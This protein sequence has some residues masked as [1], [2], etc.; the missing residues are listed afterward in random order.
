MK[1]PLLL[2]FLLAAT[3]SGASAQTEKG[4]VMLGS[5]LSELSFSKSQGGDT[6]YFS[7]ALAPN[8]GVFVADRLALGAQLGLGYQS[9]KITSAGFN[10]KSNY[11]EY[12]IAPF[13]RYYFS[14]ASK[15]KFF[16]QASYG[17]TGFTNTYSVN[18]G[19]NSNRTT[20]GSFG[21]GRASLGYSYFVVPTVALEVQPYFDWNN[22]GTLATSP[23][24]SLGLSVGFQIF[25][26]KGGAAAAE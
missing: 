17:I 19:Y 21:G 24:N 13:V 23:R 6:K 26:P 8:V 15:H 12:G 2:G 9:R 1:K 7:G 18:D 20:T 14:D 3:A 22:R 11:F 5:S 16:G 10:S 4:S 25:L